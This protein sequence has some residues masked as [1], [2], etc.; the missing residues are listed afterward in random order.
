MTEKVNRLQKIVAS[1]PSSSI[2]SSTLTNSIINFHEEL[3]DDE[4]EIVT[5]TAVMKVMGIEVPETFSKKADDIIHFKRIPIYKIIESSRKKNY[6]LCDTFNMK[7]HDIC[8][9]LTLKEICSWVSNL[10]V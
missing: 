4:E 10:E 9:I 6:F 1:P 8:E 5:C 7:I 3:D 2:D